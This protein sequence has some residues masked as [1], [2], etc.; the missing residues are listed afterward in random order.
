MCG[1]TRLHWRVS[2]RVVGNQPGRIHGVMPMRTGS[3]WRGRERC[4]IPVSGL[5]MHLWVVGRREGMEIRLLWVMLML[6]AW[7]HRLH[8]SM[9]SRVSVDGRGDAAGVGRLRLGHGVRWDGGISSVML[10]VVHVWL[11]VGGSSGTGARTC[12]GGCSV[13]GW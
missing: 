12:T 1:E 10:G 9:G 4:T 8:T 11:T 5:V 3:V 7:W 2:M 13:R 6:V